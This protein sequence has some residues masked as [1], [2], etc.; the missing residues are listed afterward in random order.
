MKTKVVAISKLLL[1]LALIC[2]PRGGAVDSKS[3]AGSD[4]SGWVTAGLCDRSRIPWV[5]S[6]QLAAD[7]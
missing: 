6:T 5:K 3:I 7:F 1:S 2:V 4:F